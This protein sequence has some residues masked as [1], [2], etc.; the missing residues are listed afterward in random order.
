LA[1]CET[2]LVIHPPFPRS[3]SAYECWAISYQFHHRL[4]ASVQSSGRDQR[5]RFS[6]GCCFPCFLLRPP[7]G[8]SQQRERHCHCF[9]HSTGPSYFSCANAAVTFRLPRKRVAPCQAHS[10]LVHCPHFIGRHF[11]YFPRFATA[12]DGGNILSS[13]YREILFR[14]LPGPSCVSLIFIHVA[15]CECL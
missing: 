4:Y 8:S 12:A 10:T 9:S 15:G 2:R 5:L 3:D 11:L 7:R 6:D 13:H 1:T 14:E